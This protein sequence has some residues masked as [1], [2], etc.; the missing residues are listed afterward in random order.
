MTTID[1][2]NGDA[3]GIC[4]LLQLRLA[5]PLE[6]TLVTGVK[7]DIKL[8]RRVNAGPGDRVNVLDISM[9]RNYDDVLR[10]LAVGAELFYVDHHMAG[11][12]PVHP[13]LQAIIDTDPDVCT[14]LLIDRYLNGRFTPWAVTAAFGDNLLAVAERVG[15]QAGLTAA[16]LERLR[17]LGTCLNYNGYGESLED[18][19]V[20]PDAL[21]RALRVYP[22]PEDFIA[23][24]ASCYQELYSG[25]REDLSRA[26]ALLPD[27]ATAAV[28]VYLLPDQ[29]WA[30][31]V[32]G[33]LSNALANSDPQRAHAVITP[34]RLGGYQVSV[35][36]PLHNKRGADELCSQFPTGGGR[37]AAAGINHLP[38]D[39]YARFVAAFQLRY[40]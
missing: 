27:Y 24:P 34:N 3:D 33:V 36:A 20:A 32:S 19:L 21:F 40:Q 25:Y 38:Q 2:F 35:R 17:M 1:V 18:L 6:T 14:S 5:E 39:Q 13:G 22:N 4:A 28:A 30:H 31:R 7:R 12:I 10:L 16:Q 15:R 37:R 23:D 26:D 8:L 11:E 9:A 29:S